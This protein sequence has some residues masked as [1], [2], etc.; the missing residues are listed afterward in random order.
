[1]RFRYFHVIPTRSGGLYSDTSG[2]YFYLL[3]DVNL[4]FISIKISFVSC[5]GYPDD[6]VRP[7]LFRIQ[8]RGN[9]RFFF[10]LVL[11]PQASLHSSAGAI[12]VTYTTRG[13]RVLLSGNLCSLQFVH[14][15]FNSGQS[16]SITLQQKRPQ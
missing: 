12:A 10:I 4:H 2:A 7:R 9:P 6:P 15:G 1:M 8:V 16:E 13:L 14:K 3:I 5:T 11:E